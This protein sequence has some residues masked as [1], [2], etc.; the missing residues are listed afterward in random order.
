MPIS[1][2]WLAQLGSVINELQ[3]REREKAA[4]SRDFSKNIVTIPA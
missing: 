1:L 3:S 4:K 2:Q